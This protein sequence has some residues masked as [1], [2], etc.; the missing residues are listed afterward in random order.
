MKPSVGAAAVILAAF[1]AEPAAASA[2]NRPKDHGQIIL[3]YEQAR[4]TQAYDED[5]GVATMPDVRT[6]RVLSTLVEYG[7]TSTLALRLKG[8]WQAGEDAFVD[9]EGRGP[10]EIGAAWQVHRDDRNVLSLYA[11]VAS[12]G[13][14]RNAGYAPPGSGERDWEVRVL[15]GR[16]IGG[17]G[18]RRLGNGAFIEAQAAHLWREGLPNEV[19]ADLTAGVHLGQ[20]WMALIQAFGGRTEDDTARWL[21]AETSLVRHLGSWSIQA[22]WRR[23]IAGRNTPLARGAV[24]ALWRRF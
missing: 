15:A 23:T 24:L 11:G 22:G 6:D 3:K 5:G 9:F 8:D 13:E 2:W 17:G 14:G 12:G 19:R 4:A 16:S 20:N 10:I 1:V 7:L 21:S 18:R